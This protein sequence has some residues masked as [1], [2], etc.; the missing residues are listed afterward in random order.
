MG[1]NHG[2]LFNEI[3]VLVWGR[4][5]VLHVIMNS[6]GVGGRDGDGTI[7]GIGW[8]ECDDTREAGVGR[9]RQRRVED[10]G[11]EGWVKGHSW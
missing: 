5:G 3:I 7:S 11:R 4:Y 10:T 8:S 6:T 9:L 2:I 1:S